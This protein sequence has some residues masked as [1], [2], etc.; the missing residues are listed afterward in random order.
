M[1][2]GEGG[3]GA[4]ACTA[5]INIPRCGHD[6]HG[7]NA[8]S[9]TSRPPRARG[10]TPSRAK[11]SEQRLKRGVFRSVV[12]LQVTIHPLAGAA[13]GAL[14]WLGYAFSGTL[15]MLS[16]GILQLRGL[17]DGSSFFRRVAGGCCAAHSGIDYRQS[18]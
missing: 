15:A 17:E 8:S 3:Q 10:S 7:M 9:F 1:D 16:D 12:D 2:I 14:R 4:R 18:R 5:P 6:S 11:L 13:G